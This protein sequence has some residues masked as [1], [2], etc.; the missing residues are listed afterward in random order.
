VGALAQAPKK[1]TAFTTEK[2]ISDDSTKVL[3]TFRKFVGLE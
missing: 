3:D 2:K 1:L